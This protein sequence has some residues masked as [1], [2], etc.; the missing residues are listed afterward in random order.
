MAF[1][2]R[3][4]DPTAAPQE[5]SVQLADPNREPDDNRQLLHQLLTHTGLSWI[6]YSP[7]AATDLLRASAQIA[8]TLQRSTVKGKCF[9][10]L[11]VDPATLWT[12]V[13]GTRGSA[14]VVFGSPESDI[15]TIFP[16]IAQ[17]FESVRP[18]L[19]HGFVFSGSAPRTF[20]ALLTDAELVPAWEVDEFRHI[21]D[22]SGY[23]DLP[24]SIRWAAR[25]WEPGPG[26]SL[27][28]DFVD[29]DGDNVSVILLC[30]EYPKLVERVG[31][32]SDGDV[33]GL[34]CLATAGG[35]YSLE[36]WNPAVMFTRPVPTGI[37]SPEL[38]ELA[39][40]LCNDLAA[41]LATIRDRP[42]PAPHF[43]SRSF[44]IPVTGVAYTVTERVRESVPSGTSTFES[45]NERAL[46]LRS[47]RGSGFEHTLRGP[48]D[49]LLSPPWITV[50]S[51]AVD[52]DSGRYVAAGRLTHQ[53][54]DMPPAHDLGAIDGRNG[55]TFTEQGHPGGLMWPTVHLYAGSMTD[56]TTI[57]LGA[58]GNVISVDLH[59]RTGT[60][61]ALEFLGGSVAAVALH[62]DGQPR[63]LLTVVA[64][65]RVPNRSSSVATANG[66]SFKE[67]CA[68][69]WSRCPR[70]DGC[71]S[72]WE[73]R[74]GGQRHRPPSCQWRT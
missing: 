49:E 63:Q 51:A 3:K 4:Q 67:V 40:T 58:D 61:A 62:R 42:A 35:P 2:R 25:G 9:L 68:P 27:R 28:R 55:A 50:N 26:K 5:D 36:W 46:R 20:A 74:P 52:Q 6:L 11:D 19:S 29:L 57:P 15:D 39:Q 17:P 43:S 8:P 34:A 47:A 53:V 71:N 38:L 41:G 10:S 64:A 21:S 59:G 65:F 31:E 30:D 12:V 48:G 16:R 54:W 44:P 69:R 23:T 45:V 18:P 14:I 1:G 7:W 73:A 70:E 24:G 22:Q 13:Q 56:A 66:S 72:T 32:S 37:G 60:I 33:S